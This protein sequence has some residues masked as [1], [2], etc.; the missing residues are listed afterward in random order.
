MQNL[1]I[2]Q[3]IAIYAIPALLAITVH[4]A[5]HGYAARFFGDRTAEMLGRLT[6]NPLKH[7]DP[8]G[9]VLVPLALL[10]MAKVSGGPL[11]LFG[12]AKPVPVAVRNFK[13]PRRDMAAVAAA[14][15][16]SNIVMAAIWTLVLVIASSMSRGAGTAELLL[17]MAYF[18]VFFNV[19]LAVFNMLP[20]PPLDGG[21]VL[22]GFLSPRTAASF[23]RIEP[24]GLMIIVA[25]M[26]LGVLWKIVGPIIMI[27]AGFFFGLAGI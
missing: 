12:W 4:E 18:G 6:L 19:I 1:N 10:A 26:V 25:L 22:G 20:I 5:S 3:S 11:F 24:Y 17:Y 27:V 23:D 21:R 2:F 8:I 15:P 13:K 7:I 16:A 9:T 14:G